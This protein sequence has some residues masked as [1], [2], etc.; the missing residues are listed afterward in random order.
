MA[1]SSFFARR[2]LTASVATVLLAGLTASALAGCASDAA[3]GEAASDSTVAPLAT[4]NL[5]FGWIPNVESMAPIVAVADGYYEDGG[6]DVTILPGGPDVVADAQIV[7]GNA[8]MGILSSE[9]L[10]NSVAAG[11]PLVA[12]AAMYQ[13]SSSAIISLEQSGITEPKDLEGKR[14]GM[15][16]TDARVYTPFFE[17]AGV[18][19][20][21]IEIVT[22]GADPAS[23]VSGE[24]DAMSGTLAN[25]PIAIQAQGYETNEIRLADYGYNRW[26]GLLVVR[27]DS[28]EDPQKRAT[29][30]AML[31]ATRQA[32]EESVAD[33]ATAAQT[34]FD[35]YGAQL[36]LQLETQ[37]AGAKIW[38]QLASEST[39][40]QGI[41]NITEEGI[42]SQQDFFD[43]IGVDVTA[44]DLF[45][46]SMQ[47]E[48]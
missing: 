5:Q 33:P 12:I 3:G 4:A 35:V 22:T 31:D 6:T 26:S 15:S 11:A 45:D 44:E 43:K 38:G 23:L 25:Q 41:M 36:G 34:V 9:A 18:D 42:E 16:Q 28:L 39:E 17:L 37:V 8:L 32:M 29:I 30:L 24:V 48:L 7:S 19:M 46:L 13:T 20:S 21:K 10:A 2:R 27:Q 1:S 47:E 14:F 40:E